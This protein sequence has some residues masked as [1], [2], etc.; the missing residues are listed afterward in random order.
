MHIYGSHKYRRGLVNAIRSCQSLQEATQFTPQLLDRPAYSD[1]AAAYRNINRKVDPFYLY[2]TTA[3]RFA[4][5]YIQD[6]EEAYAD[7]FLR[8][9]YSADDTRLVQV[10]VHVD[11]IHCAPVYYPAY[12]YTVHYLGRNL[13]T[14]V[15]GHDLR[16]GGIRVYDPNRVAI[17]SVVGMATV[18]A[19]TGGVGIGGMSGS[20]WVSRTKHAGKR[21]I[22]Y[23]C[24][25]ASSFPRLLR[26]WC[27]CIPLSSL[28]DIAIGKD[29]KR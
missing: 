29:S 26:R 7:D 15:N 25:S 10:E 16:V 23:R 12:V 28:S 24:R 6:S 19:M 9:K 27:Q 20:F 22:D 4:R 17:A 3:L 2:P 5:S 14:F 18:M 21:V 1:L 8:R 13:R 11:D